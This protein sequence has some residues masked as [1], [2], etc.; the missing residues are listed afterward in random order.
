MYNVPN[1]ENQ[2]DNTS[3]GLK[4]ENFLNNKQ[5]V[6][7]PS[8]LWKLSD[9]LFTTSELI[10]TDDDDS[11]VKRKLKVNAVVLQNGQNTTSQLIHYVSQWKCLKVAL[12]WYLKLQKP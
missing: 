4:V 9:T 3:P 7:G 2:A 1:K 6:D 12:A 8:F 5:W 11:E 10:L